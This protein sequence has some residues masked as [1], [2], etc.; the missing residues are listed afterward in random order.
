MI[1]L[2]G[3]F[4]LRAAIAQKTVSSRTIMEEIK[5]GKDVRYENATISGDLDFTYM[6]EKIDD[7]PS[8]SRWWNS[9]SNEVDETIEVDV[10]FVNCTFTDD[11]LAYIHDDP[12]GYT[13]TADFER[14]VKFE[15]CEFE[16]NSMFKYSEFEDDVSFEGS[17]FRRESTFKYA[18]FDG[19]ASF[20]RTTFNDDA[21]FKYSDFDRGVSF[22]NAI[23]EES[24]N[25]KYLD[26]RGDFNIDGMKVDD[27]IDSKYT[28]INGKSFARYLL[29]IR[30]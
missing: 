1:L 15:N 23:F 21:N 27:D 9:G 16:R 10:V 7:L 29:S 22:S 8:R 6:D 25:I 2:I 28:S 4:S 5:D 30:N 12:S 14:E 20:A 11:V 26:V 24:L 13:F 19:K 3:A 18:E 17:K